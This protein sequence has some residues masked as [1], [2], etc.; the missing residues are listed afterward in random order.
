MNRQEVLGEVKELVGRIEVGANKELDHFQENMAVNPSFA[1]GNC[2]R[3]MVAAA[4]LEQMAHIG[5]SILSAEDPDRDD[6][7]ERIGERAD[8]HMNQWLRT[9]AR[10][11]AST[12]N[13]DRSMDMARM[14]VAAE[15]L[16][17]SYGGGD[18]RALAK[19]IGRVS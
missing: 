12:S 17:D 13:S 4:R 2:D 19:V 1:F 16:G 15:W 7:L 3:A 11:S 14:Q 8:M 5:N 6:P 9:G 18:R 10:L